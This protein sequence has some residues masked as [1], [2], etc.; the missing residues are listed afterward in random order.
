MKILVDADSCPAK[1]RLLILRAAEK[2]R[3]Q[4]VFAANRPIP[5]IEGDFAAMEVCP[6]QIDAADDYIVKLAETGDLVVTRDVP[7]AA[8]LIHKGIAV[9]DDRGR[10]FTRDNIGN[11]LSIRD[12]HIEL[13]MNGA[14]PARIANY[15]KKDLNMFA[16]SFDKLL[17]K[18]C[19]MA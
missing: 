9:L 17:T 13:A 3:I 11:F 8:R 4:A 15:G 19:R 2:R 16:N 10:V 5:G 14:G 6:E 18:L 7:L 12:F 1:T